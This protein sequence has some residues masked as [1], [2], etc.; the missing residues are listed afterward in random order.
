MSLLTVKLGDIIAIDCGE[1]GVFKKAP[2]YTPFLL[3]RDSFLFGKHEVCL[4]KKEILKRFFWG[5]E[6]FL[7]KASKEREKFIR[8]ILGPV[9]DPRQRDEILK[10]IIELD[11]RNQIEKQNSVEAKKDIKEVFLAIVLE[12]FSEVKFTDILELKLRRGRSWWSIE[13]IIDVTYEGGNISFHVSDLNIFF[14]L[15][16]LY[17]ETQN[18]FARIQ[19]GLDAYRRH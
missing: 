18:I 10:Q 16:H 4:T 12:N 6:V 3:T 15:P 17:I 5:N 9:L 2:R 14:G 19:N 7:N 11:I 13:K 1:Y 8:D